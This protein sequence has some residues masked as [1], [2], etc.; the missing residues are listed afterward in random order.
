MPWN[1]WKKHRGGSG[2]PRMSSIQQYVH[3]RLWKIKKQTKQENMPGALEFFWIQTGASSTTIE[4]IYNTEIQSGGSS[5]TTIYIYIQYWISS[6]V[7]VKYEEQETYWKAGHGRPLC[8]IFSVII[9][10]KRKRIEF[11]S[12]SLISLY[13]TTN[14]TDMRKIKSAVIT[15]KTSSANTITLIIDDW[16]L[17]QKLDIISCLF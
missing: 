3:T 17:P 2:W 5:N 10:K 1:M 9:S 15:I 4:L 12:L 11:V 7:H 13:Y 6:R 14:T 8:N 16:V